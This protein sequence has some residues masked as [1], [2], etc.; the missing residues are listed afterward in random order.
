MI[1]NL[2]EHLGK[3]IGKNWIFWVKM[4]ILSALSA[5]FLILQLVKLK[6]LYIK[7]NTE[8]KIENTADMPTDY[9]YSWKEVQG[10]W[11]WIT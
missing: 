3:F 6:I 7:K 10:K 1:T 5:P 11:G 4:G 2:I 8:N 9:F